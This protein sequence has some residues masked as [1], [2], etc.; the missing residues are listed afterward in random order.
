[1]PGISCLLGQRLGC[2]KAHLP[3]CRMEPSPGRQKKGE[4][5][6]ETAGQDTEC[7][8]ATWFSLILGGGERGLR[9]P[10]QRRD[11]PRAVTPMQ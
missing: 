5:L 1:M 7:S 6:G 2:K 10:T 4:A 11:S 8:V 3:G 9:P